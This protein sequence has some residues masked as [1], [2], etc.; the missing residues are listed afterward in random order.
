MSASMAFHGRLG[1]DPRTIETKTGKSMTVASVAVDAGDTGD[2]ALWV[3]IV[4]FGRLADELRRHHKGDMLSAAGRVQVRQY[5]GS[6]GEARQQLQ[7]VADAL[8]SARTVRPAGTRQ[9]LPA[10]DAP[11]RDPFDD[12]I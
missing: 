10:P 11:P 8:L 7:I 6:D 2:P 9:R 1:G 3:G 4:A 5:T 12:P